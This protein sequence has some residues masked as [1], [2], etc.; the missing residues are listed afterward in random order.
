LQL[1]VNL[2]GLLMGGIEVKKEPYLGEENGVINRFFY[3]VDGPGFV[4]L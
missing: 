1:F 3:V 2:P 4:A